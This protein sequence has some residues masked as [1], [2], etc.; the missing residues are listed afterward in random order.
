MLPE[1]RLYAGGLNTLLKPAA[2]TLKENLG[3]GLHGSFGLDLLNQA[4]VL[5]L[6]FEAMKLTLE[7]RNSD[8]R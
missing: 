2:I 5:T 3:V 7:G 8:A 4:R 1:V 6:D